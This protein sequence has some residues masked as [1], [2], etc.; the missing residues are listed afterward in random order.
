MPHA[1]NGTFDIDMDYITIFGGQI[2]KRP[3]NMGRKAWMEFWERVKHHGDYDAGFIA[4]KQ[5]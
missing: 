3:S 2:I 5:E 4:G 1:S